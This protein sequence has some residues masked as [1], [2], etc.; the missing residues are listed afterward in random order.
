MLKIGLVG[1][2]GSGKST[3]ADFFSLRGVPVLDLD[4]LSRALTA[5]GSE[6]LEEI[7]RAFGNDVFYPDEAVDAKRNER[8]DARPDGEAYGGADDR[9][10]GGSGRRT[11][12]LHRGKLAR[13]VFNDARELKRLDAIMYPKIVAETVRWLGEKERDGCGL[14]CVDGAIIPSCGLAEKL[15]RLVLVEAPQGVL[16]SRLV[17]S[18][19]VPVEIAEGIVNTHRDYLGSLPADIFRISNDS[20]LDALETKADALLVELRSGTV[21]KQG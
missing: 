13:K 11:W 21:G 16:C 2:A 15:D 3:V 4:E 1:K 8:L 10:A 17:E 5:P 12:V 19:N 18:R 7:R 20:D 14:A 6:A 9:V